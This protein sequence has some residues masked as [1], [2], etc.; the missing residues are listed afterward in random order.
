MR[1]CAAAVKPP[2]LPRTRIGMPAGHTESPSIGNR[3]RFAGGRAHPSPGPAR[4]E[5]KRRYAVAP[6]AAFGWP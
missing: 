6:S 1:L 3:R 5:R 4:P 2:A